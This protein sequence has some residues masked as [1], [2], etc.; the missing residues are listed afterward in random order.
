MPS[1]SEGLRL[2]GIYLKNCAEWNIT[3]FVSWSLD[4]TK[5]KRLYG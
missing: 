1:N 2:L 3:E 4:S 5:W